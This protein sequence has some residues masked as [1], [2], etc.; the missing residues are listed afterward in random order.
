MS[1]L[2]SSKTCAV[3]VSVT[4]MGGAF[5]AS[6]VDVIEKGE[7]SD[8]LRE[9]VQKLSGDLK[10]SQ[11]EL[12]KLK[13][14]QSV[15]TTESSVVSMLSE[16]RQLRAQITLL[17]LSREKSPVS[18]SPVSSEAGRVVD[19]MEAERVVLL[20]LGRE[21]GVLEGAL[22][23]IG[24]AGGIAKV[25]E[26]RRGVCAAVVQNSFQGK[27]AYLVGSPAQLSAR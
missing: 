13:A 15:G 2:S 4:L 8:T 18:S 11:D 6:Q 7:S 9:L 1:L 25:V 20:S 27:L 23:R 14:L 10:E 24:Y 22:M 5:A 17:E 3:A 26:S 16:I 12:A 19:C 21:S